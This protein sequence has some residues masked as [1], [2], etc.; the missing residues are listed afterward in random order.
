MD[1]FSSFGRNSDFKEATT[2]VQ[3]LHHFNIIHSQYLLCIEYLDFYHSQYWTWSFY[4]LRLKSR[5][6][7][8]LKQ[9]FLILSLPTHESQVMK[10]PRYCVRSFTEAFETFAIPRFFS[11][12]ALTM[13]M[14][15]LKSV[16]LFKSFSLLLILS[17]NNLSGCTKMYYD[18]VE[19]E[20]MK[21]QLTFFIVAQNWACNKKAQSNQ[22][23]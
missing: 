12:P 22:V 5:F 20:W 4:Q 21:E 2:R 16:N 15:N 10:K 19:D 9:Q 23:L 7:F 17:R 11:L 6:S 1:L 13:V 8:T 14:F 18:E 3:W